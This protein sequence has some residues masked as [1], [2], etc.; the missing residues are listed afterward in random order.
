MEILLGKNKKFYKA[1]LH[2][3]SVKSDGKSTVEELKEEYM[4]RGYS[5]IAFSDH[6][7]IHGNKH[8]CDENFLALTSFELAIK[9]DPRKSTLVAHKMRC[10]HF[11]LFALD[12]DN[13]VT[14]C[15]DPIYDKYKTEWSDEVRYEGIYERS[16]SAECVNDII[17][18]AHE[19]GFLIGLN[20]PSWS[21]L[22]A[23]DYLEYEGLDFVEIVNYSCRLEGHSDD[24]NVLEVMTRHGKKV[25]C[26]AADDN[27]NGRGFDYPETDS[28]GGFVMIDAPA[29]E[30]KEVMNAL[31]NGDFYASEGP[32]IYSLTREGNTVTVKCSDA[33]RIYFC[34]DSRVRRRMVAKEEEF[35]NEASFE[36]EGVFDKFRIVVEDKRG[37]RAYTQFY[38]VKQ[39]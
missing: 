5:I 25:F 24:E 38:N 4:K 16:F 23:T 29:L 27:H 37:R 11:N 22:D 15:Y 3:H 31:K 34:S 21:L 32:E 2:C 35:V 36:I 6:D 8:L 13:T 10:I 39:R 12:E 14:P 30:Y 33:D 18:T 17:K 26:I 19:K 28:F 20:H 1:N 7:A 9:E